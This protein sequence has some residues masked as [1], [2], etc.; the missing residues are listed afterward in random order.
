MYWRL[1]NATNGCCGTQYSPQ[2][3]VKGCYYMLLFLV[4]WMQ[5]EVVTTKGSNL[6]QLYIGST[7]KCARLFFYLFFSFTL[8]LNSLN[9]Y[10]L[11]N[12]CSGWWRCA[13]CQEVCLCQPCSHHSRV[14]PGGSPQGKTNIFY[15]PFKLGNDPFQWHMNP[16]SFI[17]TSSILW[18]CEEC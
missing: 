13:R 7:L 14:F 15:F 4:F 11:D 1:G 6:R 10:R 17:L 5:W 3:K 8:Q 16:L 12:V 18:A 2:F 9:K